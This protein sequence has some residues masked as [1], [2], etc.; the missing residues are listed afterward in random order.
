MA[1]SRS[2]KSFTSF[3]LIA[4]AA[5]IPL[6]ALNLSAQQPAKVPAPHRPIHPRASVALSQKPAVDRSIVGG[7][8]TI[9]GNRKATIYL[10][11]GLDSSPLTV[12]PV[13]FLSNGV[14]YPLAPITLEPAGTSVVSVNDALASQGIAPYATLSGYVEVRYKWAWDAVCATVVSVDAI[15][16]VIFNYGLHPSD[17]TEKTNA[18]SQPKM[19][20]GKN[21]AEGI[22]W[23]PEPNV[24]GFVSLSN[25][26]SAFSEVSVVSSDDHNNVL[27]E[28]SV[29][30]APHVTKILKL[31]ELQSM[32]RGAAG[33]LRILYSGRSDGIFIGGGL[34]DQTSG[35]SAILPFQLHASPVSDTT[36]LQSYAEVGLM[37]GE[38][39][40]MMNFPADTVFV[41][42]SVVRNVGAQPLQVTPSLY[43]MQGGSSRSANLQPFTLQPLE[44][45]ALDVLS[46]QKLAGLGGF[47]GSINLVLEAQG[48]SPSLLMSGGS[49]DTKNN[50]VF[51]VPPRAV[52]ESASKTLSYWST[53][54]GD[55]T[56]VTVWNP[57]D[58]SQDYIF[59]LLYAGGRH[60]TPIHLSGRATQSFNISEIIQSQVPDPEGNVI[61]LTVHEGSA[62]IS[63]SQAD[64]EGILVVFDAGTY[65]VR[66]ATCSAYCITCNGYVYGAVVTT[67]FSLLIGKTS[68]LSLTSVWNT[69][70][71][72]YFPASWSS[73]K[74]TVATVGS[75]SSPG[76]VTGVGVGSTDI[77]ANATENDYLY[78]PNVCS[79]NPTCTE[80]GPPG[81]A[82]PG[83][84]T[85]T[86]TI[87]SFSQ[88]PILKGST[89]TVT[90]TVSPSE[91]SISLTIASSGTGGATFGQGGGT[92]TSISA[93]TTIDI[94]GSAASNN[95]GDLTLSASYNGTT[96]TDVPFS[97]TSGAC[98]LG[99]ESDSGSGQKACP[100][101]A[102]LQSSYTLSQYCSTCTVTCSSVHTDGKWTP[103]QCT[104]V[105]NH[106]SG[107]LT[108]TVTTS[109]T[110]TFAASDCNWHYAYFV[111]T[112]TNAQ[113]VLTSN[114]G[115]SIGLKCASS[116]GG[117]PCP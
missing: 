30:I 91:S 56:M 50:Y 16:S 6:V 55:D 22:W 105:A 13:L 95:V 106:L 54:N 41:P 40:P 51:Q 44:T 18:V 15:H 103:S 89:A 86:V 71:S 110:G 96:L 111:T 11:N 14:Q 82:G 17:S 31:D 64:N 116:P 20:E 100:S 85:P 67:P 43:G 8:W 75:A 104:S 66:K 88:N 27:A 109:A 92:T 113:N 72:Y 2:R 108:G 10:K 80:V 35:Y 49:V 25:T 78:E 32:P 33:G 94:Y 102:T 37:T 1:C 58:E 23:K 101:T 70:Y 93:T 74:T 97:V 77:Y 46:L 90:V 7:F 19:I 60:R 65:N 98:T 57:A 48:G 59:T 47:N 112:V 28:Q 62:R 39:D 9:D 34:E 114:T 45:R 21:V 29:Q 117:S 36:G 26:S 24:T 107:S 61:P 5:A 12:T 87:G 83:N 52:G 76:L 68:Q 115:A 63:G 99:N 53:A 81:G 3:P 69:G 4:F 38:A 84:V 42:F 79:I 73:T